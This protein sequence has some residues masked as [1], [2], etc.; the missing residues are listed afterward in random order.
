MRIIVDGLEQVAPET[1]FWLYPLKGRRFSLIFFGD[2]AATRVGLN[3]MTY[4]WPGNS[5]A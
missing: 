4:L 5:Q 2:L 3:L 1:R